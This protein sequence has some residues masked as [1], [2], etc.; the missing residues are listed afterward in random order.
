MDVI[1]L[2]SDKREHDGKV[3]E[4][5]NAD[6]DATVHSV[7]YLVLLFTYT[8][9]K[10]LFLL[11]SQRISHIPRL[12]SLQFSSFSLSADLTSEPHIATALCSYNSIDL[13]ICLLS[14]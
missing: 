4:A 12:P 13:R 1:I 9:R 2:A 10:G 6:P 3:T 14:G 11:S 7:T 5:C 8:G